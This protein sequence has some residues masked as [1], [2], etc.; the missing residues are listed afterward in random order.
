LLGLVEGGAR[1]AGKSRNWYERTGRGFKIVF[2][3]IGDFLNL[4]DPSFIVPG[5]LGLSALFLWAEFIDLP[6]RRGIHGERDDFFRHRPIYK[7]GILLSFLEA[8]V[9]ETREK[10]STHFS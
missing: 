4:F 5:A 9:E 7:T 8:P 6:V 3:K 2:G 10:G 1:D